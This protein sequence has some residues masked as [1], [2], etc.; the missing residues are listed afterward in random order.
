MDIKH[1]S[2]PHLMKFGQRSRPYVSYYSPSV[3]HVIS[4]S[5]SISSLWHPATYLRCLIVNVY[6]KNDI[7]V[8]CYSHY[9]PCAYG[10]TVCGEN[11][12]ENSLCGSWICN[13]THTTTPLKTST[14]NARDKAVWVTAIAVG[15]GPK[16]G[17]EFDLVS[18]K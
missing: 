16:R 15:K 8:K 9:Q 11:S 4:P 18:E 17:Q 6:V 2:I 3:S 7:E 12:H 13:K 10:F 1:K 14:W 5:L